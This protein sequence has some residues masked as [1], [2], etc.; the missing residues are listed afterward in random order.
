MEELELDR[1]WYEDAVFSL[2]HD[3]NG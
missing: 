2:G 1:Y 3:T